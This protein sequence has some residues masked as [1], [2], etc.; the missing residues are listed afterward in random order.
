[1]GLIDLNTTKEDETLSSSSSSTSS[2]SFSVAGLNT[3]DGS[4]SNLVVRASASASASSL[5]SVCWWN[6]VIGLVFNIFIVILCSWVKNQRWV[7]FKFGGW[8]INI[9]FGFNFVFFLFFFFNINFFFNFLLIPKFIIKKIQKAQ[10]IA[11][12][13]WGLTEYQIDNNRKLEDWNDKTES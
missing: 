4:S 1:M 11:W 2:L 7:G 10:L 8:C 6:T 13:N 3:S 5:S 9:S 12:H